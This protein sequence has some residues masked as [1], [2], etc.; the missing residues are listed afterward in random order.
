[1][2]RVLLVGESW[3]TIGFHQKGFSHYTT[4]GYEEGAAPLI[5]A[6]ET[7]FD[8]LY[9][10]NHETA[11][12]FP[13]TAKQMA[14]YDVVLFSDVGADTF[15]LHPETLQS[16]IRPNPL[17]LVQ[18]RVADGGGFAMIGGWMS[19]GGFAGAGRYHRTAIED[20][21]P[22]R[23]APYDDRVEEP[24]GIRPTPKRAD[25]PIL[26]GIGGEWPR[27]LGYNR[28]EAKPDGEV[29][30]TVGDDPYLVVGTHGKGRT[31]A[32]AGDCA[33]HWAPPEF[34][35]WKHYARH[36]QQIV[37]WLGGQ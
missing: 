36:W 37:A 34:V 23:I 6:L 3:A 18:Q 16:K 2:T 35:S 13:A 8:L 12:L 19:Y 17:R 33:P 20:I 32:Y 11:R 22:V 30:A 24:E 21:L 25:H 10:R 4:S 27:V 31:L 7:E 9:V 1:M 26:A 5:E 14:E 28:V 29:L 15:L